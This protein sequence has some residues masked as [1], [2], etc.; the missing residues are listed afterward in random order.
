MVTVRGQILGVQHGSS[1]GDWGSLRHGVCGLR[2]ASTSPPALSGEDFRWRFARALRLC[3]VSNLE[4]LLI[5]DLL[6]FFAA[7][8]GLESAVSCC[9]RRKAALV[10]GTLGS[11]LSVEGDAK[12]EAVHTVSTICSI[13]IHPQPSASPQKPS[14]PSRYHQTTL[15]S[16]PEGQS[17]CKPPNP[18]ST[19][20]VPR[21]TC[22]G[23]A[24]LSLENR[25]GRALSLT[26]EFTLWHWE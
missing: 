4:V 19:R 13:P 15:T 18:K 16:N 24:H 11:A 25:V 1:G 17:H 26:A 3:G 21:E 20:V 6:L 7:S 8:L 23:R 22:C 12:G 9:R 10:V 14:F 5:S 2:C